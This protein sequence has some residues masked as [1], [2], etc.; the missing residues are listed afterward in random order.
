MKSQAR[1]LD[2]TNN[3]THLLTWVQIFLFSKKSCLRHNMILCPKS[4]GRGTMMKKSVLLAV[5]VI[6]MAL[7]ASRPASA[8]C[9]VIASLDSLP[10]NVVA[11]EPVS[12]GFTVHYFGEKPNYLKP[13]VIATEVVGRGSVRT[14]SISDGVPGHYVA[15]LVFPSAGDWR[16]TITPWD[17]G[18]PQIMPRLIV[19]S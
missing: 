16:W 12:L 18:E 14:V 9:C 8:G 11:G 4:C 5:L 2:L 3:D 6:A 17:N 10:G 15:T 13:E 1:G 19:T 7:V